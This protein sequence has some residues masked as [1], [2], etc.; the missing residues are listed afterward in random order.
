MR[1]VAWLRSPEAG[2]A[3]VGVGKW[4]EEVVVSELLSRKSIQRFGVAEMP[5]E[6]LEDE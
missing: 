4:I 1:W 2:V 6:C 5:R 3:A